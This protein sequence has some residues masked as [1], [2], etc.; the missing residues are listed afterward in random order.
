MLRDTIPFIIGRKVYTQHTKLR[1]V[2]KA[3][4][5]KRHKRLFYLTLAKLQAELSFF[6]I[7]NFP[8]Q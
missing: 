5:F 1:N 3:I 4:Q 7:F 2:L 6:L 8:C